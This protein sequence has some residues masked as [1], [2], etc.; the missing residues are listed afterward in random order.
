MSLLGSDA[1][2]AF[3]DASDSDVGLIRYTHSNDAMMFSTSGNER[4]RID[5][6]GAMLVG[7]TTDALSVAGTTLNSGG[8]AGKSQITRS[9]NA[10]LTL[11]RLI[12]DG[13]ILAIYSAS[14]EVGS[15]GS[16]S[17]DFVITSSVSDK[18]LSLIHI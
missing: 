11:S 16:S 13:D 7:K 2:I 8:E 5:S 3:G 9:G 6:N 1:R 14:T 18:D 10:P 12:N 4:V 15:L 17:S